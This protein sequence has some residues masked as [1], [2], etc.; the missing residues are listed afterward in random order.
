[1]CAF[2]DPVTSV[3][4]QAAWTAVLR[5]DRHYD[6][7]FVYVVVTTGIYCRPSCP[8][9]SPRRQNTVILR[10]AVEAERRGYIACLRCQPQSSFSSA[11]NSIK[12]ALD[13]IDA[14]LDQ[15]ITLKILSQ[16]SGLSPHHFRVT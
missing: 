9:R 7:K 6:G 1:M 11:E 2:N 14:H 10:N 4:K 16:V 13:Y 5:R 12:A 8:A 3:S 15:P